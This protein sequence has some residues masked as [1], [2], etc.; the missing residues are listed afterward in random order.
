MNGSPTTTFAAILDAVGAG[1]PLLLLDLAV[2]VA[3]LVAGVAIYMRITP[4]H[5]RALIDEGN[6]AAGVTLGGAVLALAIPL[7]ALLATS[8]GVLDLLVWGVVALI[9]Q[10]L[11]LAGVSV[12]LRN[13]KHM[14][15]RGNLA[16]A[17]AL[18]ASQIAVA[19]LT[20]AVFVPN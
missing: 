17:I 6:T 2:C 8:G 9:L 18:A 10:L 5:E 11:T 12:A 7:A 14:I 16:A 1:L 3:L 19:L 13:L 15:E 4:F 20:A